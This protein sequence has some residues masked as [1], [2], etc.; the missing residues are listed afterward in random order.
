MKM[1][2]WAYSPQPDKVKSYLENK[3]K[4]EKRK[5]SSPSNTETSSKKQKK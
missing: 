1:I 4:G 5:S 2:H 3:S